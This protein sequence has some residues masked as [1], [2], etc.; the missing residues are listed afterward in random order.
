MLWLQDLPRRRIYRFIPR[1]LFEWTEVKR[2][3]YRLRVGAARPLVPERELTRTYRDAMR[4]LIERGRT[5]ELGDYLE[6]GVYTG[7][8]LACMHGVLDELGLDRVRL[9]GFDSFQGL[10]PVA[11]TDGKWVPGY[12]KS[13]VEFTRANLEQKDVVDPRRVELIEGWFD[14][15]LTP[16]TRNRH[17]IRKASVIMVDCDLYSS[18]RTALDFCAPVLANDTVV[19]F[20]DW[21]PDSLAARNAGEKRAFDEFLSARPELEITELDTYRRESKVFLLS[22]R[23][24]SEQA[25]GAP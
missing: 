8:S 25:L 7:T 20:D 5:E 1:R 3:D 10:P 21:L 12:F 13:D 15:T 22:R 14:D 24:A 9:F 6:F 18:A 11:R 19:I 17:N 23:G 2:H 16:E 4:L